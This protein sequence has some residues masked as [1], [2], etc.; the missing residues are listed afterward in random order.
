MATSW[1]A[2]VWLLAAASRLAFDLGFVPGVAGN[3]QAAIASLVAVA[4][5]LGLTW[6]RVR[7]DATAPIR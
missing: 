5:Y 7:H 4:L 2:V 6:W 3:G 1:G